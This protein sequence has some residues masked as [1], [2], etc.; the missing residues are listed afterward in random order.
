MTTTLD[1]N[2]RSYKHAMA[3]ADRYF[4]ELKLKEI[5]HET[6]QNFLNDYSKGRARATVKKAND[7]IGAPLRH[8][9]N[10]GHIPNNPTYKVKIDGDNAQKEAEKYL[11]KHEAEAVLK[12]LLNGIR[13]DYTTRYML[14]LQLATGAR[15]GE[16]MGLQF[17]DINFLNNRIDINKS[18]DYKYTN[19]FKPTKN[20]ESRNIS[21]DKNTMEIIKRLY[22]HQLSKK[23]QDNKQR[24]FAVNGKIPD[25]NAVN[26][27][28][29]RACKRAGVQEVTSHALRHTHAS[30]LIL[31]GVSMT[32]ISQRLGH[33]TI[34]I[35]EEVYSHVLDELAV[36]NEKE[37]AD[38][39]FNIYN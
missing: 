15:I 24:L 25:I 31:N 8:A 2:D 22:D 20:R 17:K 27:A 12:E 32:Y 1:D 9:F 14:I 6:Y 39:F 36:K 38:M 7:K 26:K 16:I 10:H 4:G 34:S 33:Q 18:W 3:L 29:R 23:I 5:D 21:V 19:D 28:L 30:L 13:V 11:N 35:T 37:S